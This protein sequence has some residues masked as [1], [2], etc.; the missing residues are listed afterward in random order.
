MSA[1]AAGSPVAST[2]ILKPST[3][4]GISGAFDIGG[5]SLFLECRGTGKATVIFLAG[6]GGPRMQMRTIEDDLL[7]RPVRVCDYDRA[8]AASSRRLA[9]RGK[10][11]LSTGSQR[12]RREGGATGPKGLFGSG[13]STVSHQEWLQDRDAGPSTRF[14]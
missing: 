8:G 12:N 3:G 13:S 7:R 4:D 14:C 1:A 9:D 11:D 10:I 5:R 2:P 6:T